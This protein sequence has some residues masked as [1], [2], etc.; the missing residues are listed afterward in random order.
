MRKGSTPQR[1]NLSARMMS[2]LDIG[3]KLAHEDRVRAPSPRDNFFQPP[4][5]RIVSSLVVEE[6]CLNRAERLERRT[7]AVG[8]ADQAQA[9]PAPRVCHL[10]EL[11]R[12]PSAADLSLQAAFGSKRFSPW[13][14]TPSCSASSL[15]PISR[16]GSIPHSLAGSIPVS[17]RSSGSYSDLRSVAVETP[18]C[19]DKAFEAHATLVCCPAPQRR[20]SNLAQASSARPPSSLGF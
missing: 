20:S 9:A 17:F 3:A 13:S 5:P 6:A 2:S 19:G 10:S 18:P 4:P 7:S 15:R 1:S 8:D 16:A 12:R 14:P 11:R